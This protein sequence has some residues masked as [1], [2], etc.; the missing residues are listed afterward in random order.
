M[1]RIYNFLFFLIILISFGFNY[2]IDQ[3]PV[4]TSTLFSGSGNCIT[5]HS[6]T[7]TQF[8]DN[9]RAVSPDAHWQSSMMANASKDP[10]WQAKVTAEVNEN[11]HLKS[12]IEDKCLTCHAPM[13][14]T[15][16]KY[17]QKD[18][19]LEVMQQDKLALDGV[20]CTVCHQIKNDN[21]GENSSFS[22]QYQIDDS[23]SI[24]GPY[25][26]P[27]TNS[28]QNFTGYTPKHGAHIK[29]SEL[30]ATCHTLITPFVNDMGEIVGNFPE[31][32]PYFEWKNS[33]YPSE[34]KS[35]QSC[36][37][38]ENRKDYIIANRP[39]WFDTKRNPIYEHHFVG[40]NTLIPSIL[41]E[42]ATA[43]GL[44][45]EIKNV[46]TTLSLSKKMVSNAID[47]E[48]EFN[49]FLDKVE[50]KVILK[51]KAG[52]KFPTGF[53]S[54][55]AWLHIKVLDN[56]NEV[57]FN[58]GD[59]DQE[60]KLVFEK[61]Y[62]PHY[63]V[64]NTNDKVQIYETVMGDVNNNPT[65]TLLRASRYLKDNRL[66]PV[67]FT[68]TTPYDSLI[69]VSGLAETDLNFNYSSTGTD[70]ITYVL[71]YSPG[72]LRYDVNLCYQTLAYPFYQD[73]IRN[74]SDEIS[75]FKSMYEKTKAN[76][77]QVISKVEGVD[78]EQGDKSSLSNRSIKVF[79]SLLRAGQS[80]FLSNGKEEVINYKIY[81]LS[82]RLI[83]EERQQYLTEGV[84]EI[85][86]SKKIFNIGGTYIVYVSSGN[87][88]VPKLV[89][90]Y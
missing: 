71:P 37:M 39:N 11:P 65:Y 27:F 30:C 44:N 68:N 29:E 54:R 53:P 81:T 86:N 49:R 89:Q 22:G 87:E 33:I 20:S 14:R 64:I 19:S 25:T 31:Q 23:K 76:K 42:N 9:G 5:C 79:P 36:H 59:Y 80:L 74:S 55:R 52:H 3:L 17:H 6:S 8:M 26:S 15:E 41:K 78:L 2:N 4:N 48:V 70:T 73:L 7:G 16:A 1:K 40:G 21:L 83:A 12:V 85:P 90:V 45:S 75:R 63:D 62:H 10:L 77:V 82:G 66:P 34:K 51:N 58:S 32:M 46:D 60:G 61:E 50:L 72:Q 13:G 28:M 24:Y 47:M 67:G 18:Y 35:C 56:N 84:H 38:P 69:S 57:V 43:L 88:E